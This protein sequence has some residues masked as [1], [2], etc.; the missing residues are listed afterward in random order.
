LQRELPGCQTDPILLPDLN[1][2]IPWCQ[3]ELPLQSRV[4]DQDAVLPGDDFNRRLILQEFDGEPALVGRPEKNGVCQEVT[5]WQQ[6]QQEH[7]GDGGP[8]LPGWPARRGG[9]FWLWSFR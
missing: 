2:P 3:N 6:G 4:P 9:S 7:G 5:N 1:Y 8:T